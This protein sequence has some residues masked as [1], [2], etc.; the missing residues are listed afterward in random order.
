MPIQSLDLTGVRNLHPVRL[1]LSPRINIFYGR[2]GSGKTSLL[3]AV[4]FLAMARSFRGSRTQPIIQHEQQQAVVFAELAG[5]DNLVHTRVGVS[6]NRA[7]ELGIRINGE[8]VRAVAS[9]AQILPLQLLNAESFLL[10]DGA[11]RFRRQFLDWGVFHVEHSFIRA[12]QRMQ[13]S[14]KQRNSMLRHAIMDS[15]QMAA[16]DAEFC[17]ASEQIDA[18]RQSYLAVLKPV[19]E[20]TLARLIDIPEL[21]I[22]YYRGWDRERGLSEVLSAGLQRD[23]QLGYTQAGPQ[24]ADIRIKLAGASAVDVLSRGQQKLVVCA[25]KLA[26]GFV[27]ARHTQQSCIYLID[28]LPAELDARHRQA[29]GLLLDQ[30]GCQV[31]ITGTEKEFLDIGWDK[32]TPVKVFHVEHGQINLV[33]Q[34][35]E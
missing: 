16:W 24:R 35:N 12:W 2:N 20:Q 1:K 8:T 22:G 21:T 29:L 17:A 13:Q 6:R 19:F 33:E 4:Y 30:L 15:Q 23:L 31:L 32:D 26:Q 18:M 10:L 25:L 14:L 7:A 5:A 28:D 9:L 11:P 27:L 3:E 34:T